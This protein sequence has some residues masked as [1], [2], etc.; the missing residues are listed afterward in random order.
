MVLNINMLG[1]LGE[2]HILC[3][4]GDALALTSCLHQLPPPPQIGILS[5]ARVFLNHIASFTFITCRLVLSFCSS[6]RNIY[7]YI[8]KFTHPFPGQEQNVSL[9]FCFNE[10]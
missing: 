4:G 5:F 3:N 6:L 2:H 1:L 8:W 7:T 10:V 9:G